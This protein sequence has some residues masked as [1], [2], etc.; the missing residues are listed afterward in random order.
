MAMNAKEKTL[1]IWILVVVALGVLLSHFCDGVVH[2]FEHF[3]A[4]GF[5]ATPHPAKCS[6]ALSGVRS[7]PWLA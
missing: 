7:L 2:A 4:F 3:I 1:L 6:A 5:H